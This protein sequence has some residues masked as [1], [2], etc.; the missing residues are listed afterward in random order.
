[1]V[2]N[3]PSI[4]GIK[5]ICSSVNR[6][7]VADTPSPPGETIAIHRSKWN[8]DCVRD[9]VRMMRSH[10]GPWHKTAWKR[11]RLWSTAKTASF[12]SNSAAPQMLQNFTL[13]KP[14]WKTDHRF[15]SRREPCKT[16]DEHG[17]GYGN[18]GNWLSIGG[19]RTVPAARFF[20]VIALELLRG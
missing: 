8:A 7:S 19:L 1:L 9:V 14:G 17:T 18:G 13:V 2:R 3:W 12:P 20:L 5:R 15:I 4:P 16:D 10:D 6:A 11:A